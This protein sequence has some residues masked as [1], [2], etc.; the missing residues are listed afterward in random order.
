KRLVMVDDSIVRG[1]TSRRIVEML[2]EAGATEV[3][4]RVSSPPVKYPCFFGIDISNSSQL[5]AAKYSTEEICKM[6]GA[7]SL[8]Y[9][10]VEGLLKTPLGSKTGFCSACFEGKY[11]MEVP[12]NANNS[13]CG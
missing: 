2:K 10:S 12:E 9:L 13:S 4:M 3:H 1:T 8:G 6:V 5:I 11:P 7:D